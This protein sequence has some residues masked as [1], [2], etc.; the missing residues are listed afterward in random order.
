MTK[1]TTQ[2]LRILE[3]EAHH[4]VAAK[5]NDELSEL[6]GL[7]PGYVANFM[8]KLVRSI[9]RKVNASTVSRETKPKCEVL[10]HDIR[11]VTRDNA[12]P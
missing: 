8:S 12:G 6:T 5:T 3:A 2:G 10:N 9:K 11:E 1:L 4:R 7:T